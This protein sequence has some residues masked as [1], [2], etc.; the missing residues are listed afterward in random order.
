MSREFDS[1]LIFC[2]III[3]MMNYEDT[4]KLIEKVATLGSIPGLDSIKE[5]MKQLD[6][7]QE[8]FPVLHVA[9]TNGKGS[10]CYYMASILKEAGYKVGCFMTPDVYC[11]E[12]KFMVDGERITKEELARYYS[13][14]EDACQRMTKQGMA[15]PTLFEMEVAVAFL[16]FTAHCV[17]LVILECGMG[18]ELDATNI[19]CQP[20]QCIFT[21]IGLDHMAF[22]GDTIS[23]IARTKAGIIKECADV[24]LAPQQEEAYMEIKKQAEAKACT[25][26]M[27]ETDE[28]VHVRRTADGFLF[29]YGDYQNLQIHTQA[30]YQLENAATAVLAM[31][32]LNEKLGNITSEHIRA[33]LVK[34]T[35]FGRFDQIS[36]NPL[37]YLDGAHNEPAALRLSQTIE[38]K[39]TNKT[40]VYIIGMLKDK[41]CE[42][43]LKQMAKHTSHIICMPTTGSR[44]LEAKELAGYARAY[45][46]EIELAGNAKEAISM[47]KAAHPDVI[48][49]FGSL[50]QLKNIK[51]DL[52]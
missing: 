35:L 30:D 10:T 43:V 8:T 21:P 1:L 19:I 31:K 34:K 41:A 13:I 7:I 44:G 15:H 26:T 3:L 33:G 2:V 24:I 18:G 6:N 25:C 27:V 51:K 14:T 42:K 22:L 4:M 16:A 12:D 39:F 36:E 50:S 37:I 45:Y 48:I 49:C 38:N 11:Y 40:I 47:A 5:L 32:R 29:D 46:S 23:L 9:G 28:I 17:D 20:L 52:E